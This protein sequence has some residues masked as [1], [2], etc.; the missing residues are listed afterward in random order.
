MIMEIEN[1][2]TGQPEEQPETVLTLAE[3]LFAD[4]APSAELIERDPRRAEDRQLRA[5]EEL[6]R[7]GAEFEG[8]EAQLVKALDSTSADV[9]RRV[10]FALGRIGELSPEGLNAVVAV[11]ADEDPMLRAEAAETLGRLGNAAAPAAKE[12]RTLV[13]KDSDSSV[14]RWAAWAY[15]GVAEDRKAVVDFYLPLLKTEQ[16][17][18]VLREIIEALGHCTGDCET[19][20][21]AL[22]EIAEN[23]DSDLSRYAEDALHHLGVDLYEEDEEELSAAHQDEDDEDDDDDDDDD[24]DEDEDDDEEYE[25][26]DEEEEDALTTEIA[27]KAEAPIVEEIA[28]EIVVVKATPKAVAKTAA[29]PAAKKPVAK[30][31]AKAAQRK[32]SR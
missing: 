18:D 1:E 6:G 29:K 28:E 17:E 10:V 21:A 27:A 24:Y 11:L 9:R 15:A 25:D 19:V 3:E 32:S 8:T 14:R 31:P 30:A 13:E 26:D 5:A 22:T 12:L 23:R 16:S 4:L 2:T 7:R 20:V